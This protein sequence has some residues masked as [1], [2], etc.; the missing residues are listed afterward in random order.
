MFQGGG[1]VVRPPERGIITVFDDDR[2]RAFYR[3]VERTRVK[4]SGGWSLND[5]S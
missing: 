1:E 4:R 2:A 5:L 3:P